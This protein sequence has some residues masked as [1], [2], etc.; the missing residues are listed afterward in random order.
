M[1]RKKKDESTG[2]GAGDQQL[3][4][5]L[6]EQAA[7]LSS[8]QAEIENLRQALAEAQ[9]HAAQANEYRDGWQRAL[10]DYSNYKRRVERDQAQAQQNAT[11]NVLRRY[12]EIIDDL[13]RA[14]SNRPLEGEAGKWAG[15]LEL[16]Y[17]KFT[18]FLEVE[19]V[20][21]ILAEGLLFD[22]NLHE[23]IVQ[24]DS[25]QHES[26]QV[27]GVVQQGYRLGERVLRPARVRVAR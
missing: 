23:A 12:L 27:I 22:P 5:Q 6:E 25:P 3:Q 11:A 17:R 15:G 8:L 4:Q 13:E 2:E 21:P 19:G 24:E 1:T 20:T 26:G 10:A 9:T 7:A 18:N 16:I 14:L